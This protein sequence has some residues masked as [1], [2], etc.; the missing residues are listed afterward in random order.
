M[1]MDGSRRRFRPRVPSFGSGGQPSLGRLAACGA[2]FHRRRMSTSLDQAMIYLVDLRLRVR[3]N[4]YALG[5]ADR[6]LSLLTAAYTAG[7][8]DMA[9]LE[10]EVERLRED[11]REHLGEA[12][13]LRVS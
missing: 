4:A 10:A 8:E 5:V 7:P 12:T 11:L 2:L 13:P 9:R 1:D 6:G 3:G